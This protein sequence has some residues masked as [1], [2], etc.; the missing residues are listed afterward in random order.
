MQL[1]NKIVQDLIQKIEEG[2]KHQVAKEVF[3]GELRYF[4]KK[5]RTYED[6]WKY[7]EEREEE[8]YHIR[9][10][11]N[12]TENDN[13]RLVSIYHIRYIYE[14]LKIAKGIRAKSLR[15]AEDYRKYLGSETIDL[16]VVEDNNEPL[17]LTEDL[18]KLNN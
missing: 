3:I 5:I 12:R 17:K 16:R 18:W 4:N 1:K 14:L 9:R 10:K 7:L 15:L 8:C 6:V 11:L 13:L 2:G